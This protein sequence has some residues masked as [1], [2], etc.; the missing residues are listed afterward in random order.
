MVVSK[1]KSPRSKAP[2]LYTK[3]APS[4]STW[5]VRLSTL[6][7]REE[8]VAVLALLPLNAAALIHPAK[9]EAEG[10]LLAAAVS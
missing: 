10:L 9:D 4:P 2:G 6:L 5:A 3:V 8:E 1:W 7:V